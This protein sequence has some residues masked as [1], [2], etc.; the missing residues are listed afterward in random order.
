MQQQFFFQV[1]KKAFKPVGS[2]RNISVSEISKDAAG[3]SLHVCMPGVDPCVCQYSVF[4]ELKDSSSKVCLCCWYSYEAP[5][6][7][8][9]IGQEF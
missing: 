3:H 6:T 9:N 2:S 4:V 5:A 1:L 8:T 7:R